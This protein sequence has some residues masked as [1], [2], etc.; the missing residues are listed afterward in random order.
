M[1]KIILY[2]S[3][4]TGSLFDCLFLMLGIVIHCIQHSQAMF[5]RGVCEFAHSFF[6]NNKIVVLKLNVYIVRGKVHVLS[7][8][9]ANI[10]VYVVILVMSFL[11]RYPESQE[12]GGV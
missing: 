9:T 12:S 3:D 1:A 8:L 6:H 11:Q 7:A 5:E 4:E 10:C 2:I